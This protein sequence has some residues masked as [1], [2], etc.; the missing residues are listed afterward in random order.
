MGRVGYIIY[1]EEDTARP[2]RVSEGRSNRRRRSRFYR[3][4]ESK[5]SFNCCSSLI[6][7]FFW[8][9]LEKEVDARIPPSQFGSHSFFKS[10]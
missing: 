8:Q 6:Y 4:G 2:S 7:A 3:E 5:V 1:G 10:M 9:L